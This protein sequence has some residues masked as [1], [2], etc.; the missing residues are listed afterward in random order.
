MRIASLSGL[1]LWTLLAGLGAAACSS[2]GADT[3]DEPV[4]TAVPERNDGTSAAAPDGPSGTQEAP[5][6]SVEPTVEGEPTTVANAVGP[7][8][9]GNPGRAI[10]VAA[11]SPGATVVSPTMDVRS[12][13]QASSNK[14]IC[15]KSGTYTI[16][17]LSTANF[18]VKV[19]TGVTLQGLAGAKILFTNLPAPCCNNSWYFGFGVATGASNVRI[20]GLT[21]EGGGVTWQGG[22]HSNVVITGN[23]I[24]KVGIQ[25]AFASYERIGN[26]KLTRN[27]IH[28]F[29]HWGGELW[30][31]SGAD[32]SNN[33]C[34]KVTECFHLNN[35][36]SNTQ[37]SYNMMH[38]IGRMGIEIQGGVATDSGLVVRGNVIKDYAAPY[39]DSF[40]LSIINQVASNTTVADNYLVA[41]LEAGGSLGKKDGGGVQRYGIGIEVGAVTALVQNNVV[42]GPYVIMVTSSKVNA[43]VK[44]NKFYNG[45]MPAWGWTGGEPGNA[46]YGNVI[47]TNNLHETDM[48]KVPAAPAPFPLP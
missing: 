44:N 38:H 31:L 19:N 43:A 30:F 45:T 11:C 48:K 41:S 22:G 21:F 14:T 16:S 4:D 8:A 46:G 17:G 13:I 3:A 27:Y 18:A 37:V 20:E 15:F 47:E 42:A 40:G 5:A 12:I 24:S 26:L 23:D 29:A 1:P 2:V 36:G 6:A 25:P 34:R 7:Y 35:P 32:I 33:Y 28:D 39:Y 10:P 9:L